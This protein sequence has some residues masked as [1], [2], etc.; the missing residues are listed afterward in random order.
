LIL[1][2]GMRINPMAMTLAEVGAPVSCI[3]PFCALD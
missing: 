1:P 3:P 2:S